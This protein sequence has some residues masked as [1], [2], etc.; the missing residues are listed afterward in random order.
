MRA[1]IRFAIERPVGV[2]VVFFAMAVF[3][4]VALRQLAVDLLPHID[5]PQITITTPYQGVAPAE[6]ET[7]ITRPVEQAVS[8]IEGVER[9]EAESSEGLSRVRLQF[10]W[11]T[12]L[13]TALDEARAAVDRIRS[14]LP[15]DAETPTIFKFDLASVPILHLG[16]SGTG[17]SRHLKQLARE[18]LSRAIERVPGVAAVEVDGGH[19]RE[20]RIALDPN[21]LE[22]LGVSPEQVAAALAKENRTVSAGDMRDAGREVVIRTAGEFSTIADIESVVV[23][24]RD[25]KP[26]R[27][28]DLGAVLDTIREVRNELWIDGE[29]GI[30]LQVYKQSGVNTIEVA[31]AVRQAVDELN[32]TY[33]ERARLGVL[34]D[35]SEF[36]T[37]AVDN[38][39]SS[40]AQG[41]LLAAFV[42]LIFLRSLRATVIVATSIP[43]SIV[44]IF[45]LMHYYG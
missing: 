20:I 33:G 29:A 30:R 28:R 40:A 25:Q 13:E 19:D 31:R 9:I 24:T 7:L 45:G 37:A 12:S 38:V 5:V 10:Q 3:G 34:W 39:E 11:G 41:A 27:V 42:L 23:A 32:A 22:A 43:L 8:T 15:A 17:D 4:L 16:L 35:A 6:I 18:E 14:Q 21:R 26:I 44:S 1:F 2:T 36:I